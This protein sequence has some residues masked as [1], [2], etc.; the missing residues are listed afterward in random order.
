[1]S[2]KLGINQY[3]LL[4]QYI[5]CKKR[6]KK[7][8]SFRDSKADEELVRFMLENSSQTEDKGERSL[9][10]TRQAINNICMKLCPGEW[11]A[12]GHCIH[13]RSGYAYNCSKGTRPAVCK[14]F[15]KWR[16]G[17]KARQEKQKGGAE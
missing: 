16:E 14:E 15:K 2:K 7:D 11:C 4:S 10:A 12:R 9:Y 8:I 3:Y 17:Q 13:C 6:T 1:M 5:S